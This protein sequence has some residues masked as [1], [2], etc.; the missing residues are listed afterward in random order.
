MEAEN[1]TELNPQEHPN[2]KP[3]NGEFLRFHTKLLETLTWDNPLT[4]IQT[5]IVLY[6]VRMTWGWNRKFFI[7]KQLEASER[8]KID[9][10][11]LSRAFNAL[12]QADVLITQK[13]EVG[14]NKYVEEWNLDHLQAKKRK[15]EKK[16]NPVV[17]NPTSCGKPNN[18]LWKTQL[19]VVEN[20]T[21][22]GSKPAQPQGQ[23]DL[24]RQYID[25]Y[26]DTTPTPKGQADKFAAHYAILQSVKNYPF[27][28]ARD[29]EMLSSLE[30]LYPKV[31]L[32]R[33]LKSWSIWMLD[34]PIKRGD[35]PRGGIQ[36]WM[37]KAGT[38]KQDTK[39]KQTRQQV[40][41]RLSLW[42]NEE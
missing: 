41:D 3:E 37:R 25:K 16:P 6:V 17:E 5:R 39:P 23:G 30:E 19:S 28:V 35:R 15:R 10:G 9:K 26:I 7:F 4:F 2:A 21:L 27:D 11:E 1:I 32:L 18:E 12:I 36:N 42:A 29:R 40:S 33:E 8:L 24:Y 13:G 20:P 31:D 34:K 22:T 14:V 38:P